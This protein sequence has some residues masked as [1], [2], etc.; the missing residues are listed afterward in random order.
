LLTAWMSVSAV[1]RAA[2]YSITPGVGIVCYDKNE[3]EKKR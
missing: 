2:G 1:S 3:M